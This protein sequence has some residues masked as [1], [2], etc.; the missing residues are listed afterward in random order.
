MAAR[1]SIARFIQNVLWYEI[2]AFDVF[3]LYRASVQI[4]RVFTMFKLHFSLIP[5]VNI[6]IVYQGEGN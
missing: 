5:R 2:F 6:A 3:R 1:I 4:F